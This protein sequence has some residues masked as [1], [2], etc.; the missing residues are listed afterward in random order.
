MNIKILARKAL[1]FLLDA[2]TFFGVHKKAGCTMI[3]G[4]IKVDDR[5]YEVNITLKDA[6]A[7]E[8]L[9]GN[10]PGSFCGGE[11]RCR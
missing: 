5:E 4:K 6:F 7:H 1:P 9:K 2:L 11:L 10:A 8:R 3:E